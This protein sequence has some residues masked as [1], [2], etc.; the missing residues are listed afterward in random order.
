MTENPYIS[1]DEA[2]M[3][4]A[5]LDAEERKARAKGQFVQIGGLVFKIFHS[6]DHVIPATIPPFDWEWYVSIDHGYN[7]PT[8]FLW[9]AVSPEGRVVTFAEHYEAEQTIDYHAGVFHTRNNMLG[10]VPDYVVGDP[11]MAQRNAVTGVSIFDEY[12]KYGVHVIPSNNDVAAGVAIMN[13]HLKIQADKKANWLITENCS[14]LIYEMQRLRWKKWANKKQQFDHN[15]HDVIHKK[16]DHA[17]DSA[18]YFFT[19]IPHLEPAVT[20]DAPKHPANLPVGFDAT[21]QSQNTDW[22][23][24]S[25]VTKTEWSKDS[26]SNDGMDETLGGIW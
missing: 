12:G 14:N 11:A 24:A 25:L 10:R 1:K 15:K 3:F 7:N 22:Q 20:K 23:L 13:R 19:F 18:R 9:H 21:S 6:E 5:G 16:D 17:C 8:A 2:D 26:V 4:L